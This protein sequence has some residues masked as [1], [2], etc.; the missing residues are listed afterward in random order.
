MSSKKKFRLNAG[1]CAYINCESEKGAL[2]E[3]GKEIK[4]FHFPKDEDRHN[5]WVEHSGKC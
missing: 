1:K 2:D 4:F 3:D 5:K